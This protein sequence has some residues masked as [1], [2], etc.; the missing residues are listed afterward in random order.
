MRLLPLLLLAACT[1]DPAV[2]D[3]EPGEDTADS[4]PPTDTDDSAPAEPAVFGAVTA[5]VSEWIPAVLTVDFEL[6]GGAGEAWVRFGPSDEDRRYRVKA[7][8]QGDGNW[9]A[10]L[11][12][13]PPETRCS[14]TPGRGEDEGSTGSITTG[15]GPDWA[16][17]SGEPTGEESGGF[18]LTTALADRRGAL[19]LDMQGRPVWWYAMLD[20]SDGG[21]STRA[22]LDPDGSSIWFNQFDLGSTDPIVDSPAQLI[23]VSLDGSELTLH[24]IPDNHHDFYLHDDGRLVWMGFDDRTVDGEFLRGDRL[25]ER[26]ADGNEREL[27]NG[28]DTLEYDPDE[29]APFPP[30]HWTLGNHLERDLA[31]GEDAW[32]LSFKNLDTLI[33][34]DGATGQERWRLGHEEPAIDPDTHFSG[35]HG[36]TVLEDTVLLFDNHGSIEGSRVLELTLDPESTSSETVWEHSI[37]KTTLILGDVARLDSGRTIVAWGEAG[38]IDE[39]DADGTLLTRMTIGRGDNVF[40]IGFLEYQESIGPR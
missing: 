33:A 32:V 1:T 5:T 9:R 29:H 30:A 18:V 40:P 34:V 38:T 24:P 37:G 17:F 23:Q 27:W 14:Y 6:E 2:D 36:F 4:V 11:V 20:I 13:C 12:G 10:V 28:W 19:V 39:L 3:T 21:L 26:D 22:A 15:E 8:D 16:E 31:A 7:T 35:Q 25:V